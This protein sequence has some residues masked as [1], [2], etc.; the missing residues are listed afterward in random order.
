MIKVA[1]SRATST[2]SSRN[3]S[4]AQLIGGSQR[5]EL[6]GRL[7]GAKLVPD[8]IGNRAQVNHHRRLD[9]AE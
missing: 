1:A 8:G 5:K 3:V 9:V 7:S 4:A 2:P 6:A